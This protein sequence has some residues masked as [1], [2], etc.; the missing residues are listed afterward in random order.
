MQPQGQEHC[1]YMTKRPPSMGQT[2]LCTRVYGWAPQR[3][4]ESN[5]SAGTLSRH[6]LRTICH[7]TA[8]ERGMRPRTLIVYWVLVHCHHCY[9]QFPWRFDSQLPFCFPSYGL[10]SWH[11]G[12][13]G[14][15]ISQN[16]DS[17]SCLNPYPG[18]VA[19]SRQL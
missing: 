17:F 11:F 18:V 15:P 12:N 4:A 14:V 7:T 3:A 6:D 10:E 19:A 5:P 16:A 13:T 9:K 2:Q 8:S 1:K